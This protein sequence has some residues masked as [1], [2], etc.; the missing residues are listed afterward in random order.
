MILHQGQRL[1]YLPGVLFIGIEED[2]CRFPTVWVASS[3][4]LEF[5]TVL[6]THVP[7]ASSREITHINARNIPPVI[8]PIVSMAMIL[9]SPSMFSPDT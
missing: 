3:V 5:L 4:I 9:S 7:Q 2:C 1:E 6:A 8:P